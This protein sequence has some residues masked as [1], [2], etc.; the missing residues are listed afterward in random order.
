MTSQEQTSQ[1]SQP[2][3]D[4]EK[5]AA[6]ATDVRERIRKTVVEAVR[7]GKVSLSDVSD[8]TRDVVDGA[9]QGARSLA[10]DQ[11]DSVL[12][13]VIDGMG[14]AFSSTANAT[15]LAIEEAG[16]RGERFARED[17]K[18]AVTHL[19]ELQ[20][21]FTETVFDTLQQLRNETASQSSDFIEHAR[22]VSQRVQPSI[23]QA[24]HAA[25]QHPVKLVSETATA[26]AKAVPKAAG[27]LLHAMS[28]M[29]QGAGDLLTGSGKPTNKQE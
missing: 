27:T 18:D 23:E 1:Q 12:R 19:S 28:G 2:R 16:S 10:P 14:D 15:R 21:A 17:V 20:R 5:I 8:L 25:M 9:A 3:A 29:L 4:A 22:R 26:G 24:L 6:E 11:R 7:E 13:Q